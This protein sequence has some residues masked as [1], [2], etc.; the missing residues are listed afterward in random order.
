LFFVVQYGPGRIFV[1]A[2]FAVA[3]GRGFG[4]VVAEDI[5]PFSASIRVQRW[6]GHQRRASGGRRFHALARGHLA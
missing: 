5:N 3:G 4:L 6:T 2:F 1:P